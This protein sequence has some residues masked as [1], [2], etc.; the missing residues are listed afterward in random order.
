[1]Q[2][3]IVHNHMIYEP[4]HPLAFSAAWVGPIVK[5]INQAWVRLD[6]CYALLSP[7]N[8]AAHHNA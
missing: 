6:V 1:M 8:A 4:K 2:V 5:V 7:C 3:G